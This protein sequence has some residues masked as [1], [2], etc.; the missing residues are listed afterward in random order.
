MNGR[1]YSM[2]R[3]GD[4]PAQDSPNSL[5]DLVIIPQPLWQRPELIW[6]INPDMIGMEDSTVKPTHHIPSFT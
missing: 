4:A 2:S 6:C 1:V 3:V 5:V